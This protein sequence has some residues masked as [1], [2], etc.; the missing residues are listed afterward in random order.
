MLRDL[1]KKMLF[2]AGPRQVGKTTL[3]KALLSKF[4]YKNSQKGLYLNWDFDEDREIILNKKWDTTHRVI[5]FDEFHKYPHWKTWIKGVYDKQNSLHHFIL[6]GSARMDVYMDG[7]DSLMGRYHY[8]RLHPITLDERPPKMTFQ[9]TLK[10]LMSV[11]GFPEPFLG[12]NEQEA[13]RWRRARLQK[14]LQEDI[15]DLEFIKKTQDLQLFLGLLRRRVGG[16]VVLSQLARDV[17]I[18]PRTA[19]LWLLAL[20]RMYVCFSVKAYTYKLARA[21]QKPLK[22]YFFDNADV[23]CGKDEGA[24]FE[25]L[26]AVH[27]LKKLHYLEDSRGWDMD[28][29]FLR[30]KEGREVGFVV[31][32]NQTLFALV[33]T[34]L[35]DDKLSPS[36]KYYS[37]KLNPQ[38]AMQIVLNLKHEYAT[39]NCRVLKLETALL[40]LFKD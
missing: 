22:V 1:K 28:L 15:R 35:S 27:L 6:T 13:R 32:K 9:E 11:G 31:L 33:E 40:E 39:H 3:A 29:K 18:S 8:W 5:V 21:V 30:D 4:P 36:L 25:N 14:V 23:V 17:Q 10:R 24:R 34:K 7:G 12:G 2:L 20:N 26:V 37:A 16:M 19:K 38:H